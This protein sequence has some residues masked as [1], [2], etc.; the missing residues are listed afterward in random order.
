MSVHA[1][2]GSVR[3]IAATL[4]AFAAMGVESGLKEWAVKHLVPPASRVPAQRSALP[5]KGRNQI[6]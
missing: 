5:R 6:W 3:G 1:S 4:P 2:K